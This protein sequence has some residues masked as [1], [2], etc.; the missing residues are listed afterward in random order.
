MRGLGLRAVDKL[1]PVKSIL[2]QQASGLSQN[3]PK[4]MRGLLPG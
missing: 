3:N 4:L 1:A 2:M